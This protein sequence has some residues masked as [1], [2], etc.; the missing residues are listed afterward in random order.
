MVW[1]L[2]YIERLQRDWKN[3]AQHV[4]EI[5]AAKGRLYKAVVFGSV[6]K[7]R[8]TGSSDLDIALFYDE[9]LSDKEKIGR[10][11]SVL[12]EL[13]EEESMI[14]DLEVLTKR[15]EKFFLDLIKQ[16]FEV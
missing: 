8:V 7:G 13:S 4:K 1:G 9:E 2:A 5:G 12:E 14:V 11:L 6:I 10:A 15:E 3:I 16:Y